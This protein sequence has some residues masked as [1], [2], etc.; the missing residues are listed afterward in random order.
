MRVDVCAPRIDPLG[1]DPELLERIA[2]LSGELRRLAPPA[3]PGLDDDAVEQDVGE[4][5]LVALVARR[6]LG[7][8]EPRPRA[9]EVVDVAQPLAELED[10][11]RVDRRRRRLAL[12]AA[13]PLG[14][15]RVEAL[16]EEEVGPHPRAERRRDEARLGLGERLEQLERSTC[17]G[18]RLREVDRARVHR[19]RCLAACPHERDRAPCAGPP[20]RARPRQTRPSAS[21]RSPPA[22]AMHGRGG[23]R[24][25]VPPQLLEHRGGALE[26]ARVVEVLG[27]LEPQLVDGRAPLRDEAES[28]VGQ[29]GRRVGGAA[30]ARAA[31][32]IL[33]RCRATPASRPS[34]AR[35]RWRRDLLGI[36]DYLGKRTVDLPAAARV[37]P[38]SRRRKRRADARTRSAGRPRSGRAPLPPPRRAPRASTRL[39]SGR[40]S[41]DARSSASR[42]PRAAIGRG[43]RPASGGCR[44]PAAPDCPG[45]PPVE[46]P[47]DLERVQRVAGRRLGDP[48]ERR[49]R[50]RPAESLG[51]DAVERGDRERPELEP[52]QAFPSH[53]V[54]R[55]DPPNRSGARESP[56]PARL[57]VAGSRTRSRR[58]RRVEPLEVVDR[59]HDVPSAASA[60]SS[61]RRAVPTRRRSGGRSASTRRRATSSARRCGSGKHRDALGRDRRQQIGESGEGEPRLRLGRSCDQHD[62][63]PVARLPDSLV[64]ERCLADSRLAQDRER[65]GAAVALCQE[66]LHD[67]DLGLA[68]D[69]RRHSESVVR[70]RPLGTPS[71]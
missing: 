12:E 60:R 54:G 55:V 37:A 28:E 47:R 44:E 18:C 35:A 67:R 30:A 33:R 17:R 52:A 48:H 56:G 39:R 36:A 25:Q 15:L 6:L 31:S 22:S 43:L 53:D 66:R 42:V 3:R 10:D 9:V 49:A 19:D 1:L 68:P 16:A 58:R 62:R 32:R 26:V 59:E 63:A 11:P 34:Q 64:P 51:N 40:A 71:A 2:H 65:A 50:E 21:S 8:G 41:A 69:D 23:L 20:R 57:S 46:Q 38:T 14:R 29:L 24:R 7:C 45:R 4:R 13:G 61:E 27:Q 70:G 5:R